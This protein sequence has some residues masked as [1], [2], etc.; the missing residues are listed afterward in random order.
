VANVVPI[1]LILFALMIVGKTFLRNFG[2]LQETTRRHFP[3][4]GIL[5]SR[6]DDDFLIPNSFQVI[7][8]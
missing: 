7:R 6:L 8:Q 2:T 1:S 3:K 5:N 4:D